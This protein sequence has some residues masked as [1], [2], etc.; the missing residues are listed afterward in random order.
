MKHYFLGTTGP[1]RRTWCSVRAPP[2]SSCPVPRCSTVAPG[3]P[4]PWRC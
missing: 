3:R 4:A 2:W 1:G